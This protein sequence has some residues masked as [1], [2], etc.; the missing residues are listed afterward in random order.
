MLSSARVPDAIDYRPHAVLYAVMEEVV[1]DYFLVVD[2]PQKDIDEIETQVCSG[3][4]DLSQRIYQLTREM[5]KLSARP[6]HCARSSAAQL[7]CRVVSMVGRYGA[8]K[9]R[10]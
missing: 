7:R 3:D 6:Q 1:D 5:I 4:P 2:E 9:W 8:F 10:G